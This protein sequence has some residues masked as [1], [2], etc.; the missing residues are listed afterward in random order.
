VTNADIQPMLDAMTNLASYKSAHGLSDT[1]L[2]ALGDINGDNVVD[3]ADI[4]AF[5][6]QLAGN[7]GAGGAMAVPELAS[8]WLCSLGSLALACAAWRSPRSKS[9]SRTV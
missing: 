8:G 6:N 5:L 2:L 9:K 4:P 1:D 3:S 7:S